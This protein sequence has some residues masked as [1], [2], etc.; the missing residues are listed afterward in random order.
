MAMD[1]ENVKLVCFDLNNTLIDEN[2]WFE[3]NVA[4][5]V[6]PE[7]D[8]Q[9]M[10]WYQEG[11]ITYEEGQKLLE[12]IYL[13]RGKAKKEIMLGAMKYTYREGAQETVKYLLEKG[14][15]VAILSGA[16]DLLVE[17]V[18]QELGI[19]Y[20]AAHNQLDFDEQGNF[21]KIIFEGDDTDFKVKELK[22]FCEQINIKP[23]QCVFVG[24]DYNDRKVFDLTGRGVTFKGTNIEKNAWG[25]IDKLE[26]LKEIL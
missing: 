3:L 18:A 5:G 26:D 9:F 25:V 7:E 1:R 22:R 20:Y 13:S 16:I 17:K 21:K 19:K 6:T 12:R 23:N 2:T 14:Y 15:E 11:V 24:D 8:N 10:R 4:M